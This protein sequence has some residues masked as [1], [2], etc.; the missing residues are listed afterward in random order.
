MALMLRAD[1]PGAARGRVGLEKPSLSP[2][3]KRRP[4]KRRPWNGVRP[5]SAAM[6]SVSW[7]SPPAPR[8]LA[9]EVLEDLGLED[10]AADDRSATAPPPAGLLDQAPDLG[11]PAVVDA[12]HRGCRSGW[13]A[14]AARPRPRR[15]CRR[16]RHRPRPSASGRAVA[17]IRSSG[18]ITANGSSPTGRGR[19]RPHGRG[20][21]APAGGCRCS[22]P[23]RQDRRDTDPARSACPALAQRCSSSK[24]ESK[25]SS[26]ALLP[27]PVTKM[28][29]RC[30]PPAP[31]RPH[32]GS[33]A[34]RRPAASPWGSPWW[35]A[36]SACRVRR[37]ERRPCGSDPSSPS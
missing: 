18:R 20:R 17:S 2:Q 11:Q 14:R 31:P 25:W 21:A 30:R 16:S 32:T 13:S 19:T 1:R 15:C 29:A 10:V 22:S 36:G 28:N 33:A 23:G 37:P 3:S 9:L 8:S 26:I 5:I 7:I 34:C 4:S 12:R 24:A 27:R 6:A 35:P